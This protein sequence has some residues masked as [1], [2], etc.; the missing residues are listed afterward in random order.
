[1]AESAA[2]RNV[3]L[4]GA[5]QLRQG[6][7][8]EGLSPPLLLDMVQHTPI[9]RFLDRMAASID[10]PRA[11]GLT[12][13]INLN[14]SDLGEHH[15]LRLENAVLHHRKAPPDASANATLTLT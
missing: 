2:W 13:S 3:Y 9:E 11:D 5:L 15:V 12:L 6:A 10:G 1:M 8:A 4:T 7:P 14:F